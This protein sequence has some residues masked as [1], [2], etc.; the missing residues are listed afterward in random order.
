MLQAIEI[1]NFKSIEDL[2][3]KFGRVNLFIGENG[4]GKSTI[5]EALTFAAASEADKLDTEFL[6]NRGIRVTIPKLMRSNFSQEHLEEPISIKVSIDSD[7]SGRKYLINNDNDTYSEWKLQTDTTLTSNEVTVSTQEFNQTFEQYKKMMDFVSSNAFEKLKGTFGDDSDISKVL[8]KLEEHDLKNKFSD[9]SES[10][11]NVENSVNEELASLKNFVIYA[12]QNKQLRNLKEEGAIRPVGIH[13]EGL[14]KL[15][16]EIHDKQPEAL[17][18]IEK[19]LSLISWY[20]S[21]DLDNE[22][23][24]T[25]DELFIQDKYLPVQLTQRSA[26][27]G[28]LY[29]MFYMALIVSKNTPRIFAIDNIDAALNPK[30]C[31]KITSYLVELAEKYD[32]QIFLTTQN[33]ATLDGINVFEDNQKLFV[34]SRKKRGQTTARQFT[35][36]R[37]PKTENGEL[38]LLSEAM[39]KGFIG[40]IPRGF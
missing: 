16:R 8:E 21:M 15:L 28:F 2:Q 1:K 5:L 6:E 14:F 9:L 31:A 19:G 26:N 7:G 37:M 39:I 20:K 30:L 17:K 27:E 24:L 34:V 38:I 25:E 32:K 3:L 13:G 18:D 4:S 33:P 23:E 40:A 10:V 11:K 22:P 12:P 29:V 35:S 36:D